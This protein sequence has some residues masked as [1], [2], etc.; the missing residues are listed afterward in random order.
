[1]NDA[2]GKLSD[3]ATWL[4]LHGDS[5]YRFA[6]LRVRNPTT[7]EDLVQETLLAAWRAEREARRDDLE[8]ARAWLAERA[9]TGFADLAVANDRTVRAVSV[10]IAEW[11]CWAL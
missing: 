11:M 1:M 8:M 4:D 5:L 9:A 10:T 7:A 3:P 6:L 2:P